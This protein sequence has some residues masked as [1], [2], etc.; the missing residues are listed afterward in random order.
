M[1]GMNGGQLLSD[2]ANSAP[3]DSSIDSIV[4]GLSSVASV[5]GRQPRSNCTWPPITLTTWP[6]TPADRSDASQPATAEMLSGEKRS[7]SPSFGVHEAPP[8]DLLGQPGARD[9]AIAFTRTPMRSSS[10]AMT[11]VIDAMPALAAA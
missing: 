4:H 7:N 8:G 9:R 10:R 11:I 3:R 5:T 1:F 2:W 6:V